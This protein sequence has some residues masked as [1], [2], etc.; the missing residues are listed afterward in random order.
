VQEP[1]ASSSSGVRM[2]GV[3]M[4]GVRMP[5][6]RMPGVRVSALDPFPRGLSPSTGGRLRAVAYDGSRRGAPA[7]LSRRDRACSGT[8][9]RGSAAGKMA[10][11]IS[12]HGYAGADRT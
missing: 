10:L 11:A 3:R 7:A 2:P 5:G 1:I 4:P 9:L 6:V 8:G 12:Y